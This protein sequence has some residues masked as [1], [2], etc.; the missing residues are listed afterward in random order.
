MV[1]ILV[2][3][4]SGISISSLCGKFL[5]SK[6]EDSL[7]SMKAAIVMYFIDSLDPALSSNYKQSLFSTTLTLKRLVIYHLPSTIQ[8]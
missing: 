6:Q 7:N 4:S 8:L 5:I 1:Q 3:K 2:M